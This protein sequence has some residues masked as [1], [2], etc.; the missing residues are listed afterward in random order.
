MHALRELTL[1][2]PFQAY[3]CENKSRVSISRD[4]FINDLSKTPQIHNWRFIGITWIFFHKHERRPSAIREL[5][6]IDYCTGNAETVYILRFRG[7]SQQLV[8]YDKF[9]TLSDHG[10]CWIAKWTKYSNKTFSFGSWWFKKHH[11]H[12]PYFSW[13]VNKPLTLLW[14]VAQAILMPHQ[15]VHTSTYLLALNIHNLHNC[16][17]YQGF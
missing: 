15:L 7:F 5:E 4:L 3:V 8:K 11:K 13:Q 16:F 2:V 12:L 17:L 10:L 14:S 6:Y 9:E 1:L